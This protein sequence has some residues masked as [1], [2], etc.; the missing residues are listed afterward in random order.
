MTDECAIV[1]AADEKISAPPGASGS[2]KGG[3]LY[4]AATVIA[5][6]A[7]LLRY[8]TLAR[9]LGPQQL[10]L[11]STIVITGAFFDLIS[12]G[13][14]DRF[15]IQDADGEAPAVQKLVQLVFIS[16]ACLIALSIVALS[17]PI[18]AFYKAPPLARGLQIFAIS[19]LVM[20]FMHLDNRRLQRA[21]DFRLAALMIIAGETTSVVGTATAAYFTHSFTAI[22]FG[23]ISRSI[24]TVS[25]SHIL[26]K[27][28]YALG[29]SKVI[30]PRF[31]RYAR[32][33]VLTG[34]MLFVGSQSDRIIVARQLGVAALG[35]YSAVLLLIYYPS[36]VFLNFFHAL[37]V[38]LIAGER[39]DAARR[40]RVGDRLTGQ[41]LLLGLSMM[42]GF[43]LVAPVAVPLLFGGRYREPAMT[44]ALIG[45]LQVLR[46]LIVAP[47]TIAMSI[48]ENRTVMIGNLMR[49]LVFPGAFLGYRLVG[50]LA[51]VVG[52]FAVAEAIALFATSLL[53]NRDTGRPLVSGMGRLTVFMLAC[54]AISGLEYAYQARSLLTATACGLGLAAA[55]G[56]TLRQEATTLKETAVALEARTTRLLRRLR[57]PARAGS[58]H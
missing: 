4:F 49:L 15:L 36:A 50:G 25:L 53:V 56:W 57:P 26:A 46:F 2:R 47:T 45:I 35:H 3:N 39:D 42:L 19:P 41:T 28:P 7:A 33:L 58:T 27:R 10:G 6:A 51:G 44:V 20:G 32:P 24:V 16:R 43:A 21:H 5:M 40:D 18:A 38:P 31:F 17:M 14:S 55:I 22:L 37:Y 48:G 52:G 30:A 54:A 29:Y 9:F 12:D 23:L 34:L 13:G 11:A 8:V 1:G